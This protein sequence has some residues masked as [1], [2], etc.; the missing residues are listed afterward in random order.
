MESTVFTGE[1]FLC[2]PESMSAVERN[3]MAGK[4]EVGG[5]GLGLVLELGILLSK[6]LSLSPT[7]PEPN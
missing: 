6:D 3:P 4:L 5:A 2:S 7:K 1:V